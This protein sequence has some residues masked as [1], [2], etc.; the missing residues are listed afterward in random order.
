MMGGGKY[1][2]THTHG[3]LGHLMALT[4]ICGFRKIGFILLICSTICHFS[5]PNSTQSQFGEIKAK[6]LYY[7]CENYS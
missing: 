1:I 4:L 7:Q 5:P 2:H 3:F 6:D